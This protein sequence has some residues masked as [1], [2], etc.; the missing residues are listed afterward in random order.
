MIKPCVKNLKDFFMLFFY[1]SHQRLYQHPYLS[2]KPHVPS[3]LVYPIFKFV[4]HSAEQ[5]GPGEE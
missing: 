3:G 1:G 5:P 2:L 4:E